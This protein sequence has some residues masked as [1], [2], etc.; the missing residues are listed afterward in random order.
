MVRYNHL[1]FKFSFRKIVEKGA[2]VC[3][4][5]LQQECFNTRMVA[6]HTILIFVWSS[7]SAFF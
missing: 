1:N 2:F 3:I 7:L 6:G 5:F 4:I